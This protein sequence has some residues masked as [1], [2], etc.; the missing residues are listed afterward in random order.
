[1]DKYDTADSYIDSALYL[2]NQYQEKINVL[3]D[4][5]LKSAKRDGEKNNLIY[6]LNALERSF[7]EQI[8]NMNTSMRSTTRLITELEH[9]NF[10]SP[11]VKENAE[12]LCDSLNSLMDITEEYAA[13]K[14]LG[15]SNTE[16]FFGLIA[17]LENFKKVHVQ[18]YSNHEI[19]VNVEEELLEKLPFAE[20]GDALVYTLDIRSTRTELNISSF[21]D[22]LKLLAT[23]LQHLER[24][25]APDAGQSIYMQKV[26]SGSLKA[27]FG[28]DKV[29]FSIFPD[30][31]TSISN[32][33][34]TW[35]TTPNE[36]A[37][38]DAE[39][40]KIKAETA[41][42]QAQADA[43]MIQNEGSKLAIVNSQIDYLSDKLHLDVEKNPEYKEQIQKFCLPLIGYLE[44][45][46]IGTVNG[47]PYDIS[48]EVHL[49]EQ[50]GK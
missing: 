19:L 2:I 48:K 13:N 24:L 28:S 18:I 14:I 40:E 23:C 4:V 29:D 17:E 42:I 3:A 50:L 32:A 37:K 43:Q 49:L 36:K 8:A 44:N 20:D 34:K 41:L 38:M 15:V 31:I 9:M 30:L 7:S 1:M 35:R 25:V 5:F 39:T 16:T 26:E 47:I 45:N 27:I 21:S 33:I 12:V 22:D 10:V 6:G 11:S 46:P